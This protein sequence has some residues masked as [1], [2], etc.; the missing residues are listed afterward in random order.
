VTLLDG[1]V[2]LFKRSRSRAWQATFKVDGRWV[3]VSTKCK[4]FNEAKTRARELYVEY[5]VRLKNGLPVISK[6]FADVAAVAIAEMD[7][8]AERGRVGQAVGVKCLVEMMAYMLSS[9]HACCA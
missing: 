5:Q 7:R 2:R 6:R 9:H 1:D 8:Q 3:R 4:Q